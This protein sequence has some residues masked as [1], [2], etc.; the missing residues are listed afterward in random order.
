[1][2][3]AIFRRHGDPAE[4]IE[5]IEEDD[6]TP[7]PGEVRVRNRVMT[8][9]PADLLSIEGRYGAEPIT[10]P[11][12]PG[13]GAYGVVDAVGEGVTR[14]AVG[15]AVLPVGGG[16]WADTLILRERM[17]PKAPTG[18]DPEQ[19]ALMRANPG[20][21]HLMLTDIVDLQ[22]GD[23]VVQNAANSNVGRMVIRFARE[24]GLHTVNIVRRADVADALTDDGADAV[25]VD[26]GQNIAA[27]IAEAAGAA[28]KL[29]LDAV[30]GGATRALGAALA[31]RG[32]VVAY[33]LLSGQ[34]NQMDARDVVFRDVRLQGFWLFDWYRTATVEK[35]RDLHGFLE[36]KL[37]EGMLQTDIEAR[38]PLDQIKEAVAHAA[39]SGRNGKILLKGDHNA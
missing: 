3:R 28:P 4:V 20:T 26:Q 24:R 19:A 34:P 32:T 39:R 6:P 27:A 10:L 8:I 2:K 36:A 17:A 25:I 22:P 16:F 18:A 9:N 11:A 35:M 23:W 33:G 21:A 37:A 1:M 13:V 14:L 29:A 38:Y 31:D 7:G 30:G 5:I 15:D 12:T